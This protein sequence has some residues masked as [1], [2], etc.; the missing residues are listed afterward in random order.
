MH[1]EP[2]QEHQWLQQIVGEW[3]SEME[4]TMAPGQP[5]AKFS[6]KDRVRSLG[7]L[8]VICEGEGE[9]PDGD[10]GY[11]IMTLGYDPAKKRFVGTFIGSMMAGMW[12]YEGQLAGNVLTL[13]TE[14]PSFADPNKMA[15]YQD[16]LEIVG[17]D[18]RIL[19]SRTLG[20]DGAWTEFMTANYRRTK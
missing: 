18:H 15:K 8:W 12:L 11:T 10:T 5:P 1:T 20:E 17:P 6:G 7:G 19:K 9:M 16:I 13:D 14:G 3:T 2:Q 4:A